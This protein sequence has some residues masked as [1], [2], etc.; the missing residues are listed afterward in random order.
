MIVGVMEVDIR[1]EDSF[2]LKDKRRVLKSLIERTKRNFNVSIAEVDSNEVHN[3][4]T[5]G[6]A[7]VSNSTKYIDGS[8]NKILDF[9]E[10]NFNIEIVDSRRELL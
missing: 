1:I 4:A 7:T 10:Y 6:I 3:F 8:F 9:W 2:S 5:I